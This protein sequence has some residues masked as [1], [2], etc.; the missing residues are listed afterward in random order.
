MA[1]PPHRVKSVPIRQPVAYAHWLNMRRVI[2]RQQREVS[3]KNWK[4]L[5]KKKLG[6]KT[7]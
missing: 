1:S 7:P 3:R 5:G 2:D 6:D 4:F